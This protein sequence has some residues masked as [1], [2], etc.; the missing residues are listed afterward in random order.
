M[1]LQEALIDKLWLSHKIGDVY[2]M[3]GKS[4]WK[5][6]YYPIFENNKTKEVYEEP[7]ALIERPMENGIDF[8]EVPLRYL[9]R[10]E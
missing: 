10:C 3:D 9:V 7:R 8:R 5:I 6:S 1:N 2:S 4:G